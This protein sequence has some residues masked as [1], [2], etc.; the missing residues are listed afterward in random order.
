MERWMIIFSNMRWDD[1]KFNVTGSNIDID[2]IKQ[3]FNLKG[4][5]KKYNEFSKVYEVELQDA[6]V[7]HIVD[8]NEIDK[9][10]ENN[11]IIFKNRKGLHNEIKRYIEF[12]LN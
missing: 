7:V 1:V 6:R 5:I 8:M 10:F 2:I 3:N 9:H 4:K 12:S 11:T